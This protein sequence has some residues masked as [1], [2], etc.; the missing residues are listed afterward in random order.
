MSITVNT[1][2]E[3]EML[4]VLRDDTG[5]L[6]IEATISKGCDCSDQPETHGITR[7]NSICRCVP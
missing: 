1:Q 2:T 4:V 3:S 5:A 6:W 7:A